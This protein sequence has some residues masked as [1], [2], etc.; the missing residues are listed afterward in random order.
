MHK[1]GDHISGH[2][3]QIELYRGSRSKI[4]YVDKKISTL[5]IWEEVCSTVTFKILIFEQLGCF[6]NSRCPSLNLNILGTNLKINFLYFWFYF[7]GGFFC[8][9]F[10]FFVFLFILLLFLFSVCL[11]LS[12]LSFAV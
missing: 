10:F 3:R 4:N 8:F 1:P 9:L 2:V 11:D 12:L 5:G 6:Y 7:S